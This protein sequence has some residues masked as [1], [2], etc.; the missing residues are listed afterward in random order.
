ASGD[1]DVAFHAGCAIEHYTH[2]VLASWYYELQ[3]GKLR[4]IALSNRFDKQH[5][6]G[7]DATPPFHDGTDFRQ[8]TR[9]VLDSRKLLL[10]RLRQKQ[11][12]SPEMTL[13][14]FALPSIP[15]FRITRRLH[16][17]FSL[18]ECHRHG[19]FEDAVG[20]TGDWRR[21]GPIY[22]IP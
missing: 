22:P 8:V 13:Y 17:R 21:R 18:G 1:A 15:D 12:K 4:L 7:G 3:D 10:E 19:W 5:R 16:N 20:I 14:P 6:D 11:E 9:Q 2:N